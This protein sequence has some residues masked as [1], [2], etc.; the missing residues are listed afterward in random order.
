MM[1]YPDIIPDQ[2]HVPPP[3]YAASFL[4]ELA[5]GR[6][7]RERRIVSV[8]MSVSGYLGPVYRRVAPNKPSPS[9]YTTFCLITTVIKPVA[10]KK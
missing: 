5:R 4:L 1:H 6:T 10:R 9:G 2:S 8:R 3:L 7:D